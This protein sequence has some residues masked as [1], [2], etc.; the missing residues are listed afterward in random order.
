MHTSHEKLV[1]NVTAV[2][3]LNSPF[4]SV[5]TKLAGTMKIPVPYLALHCMHNIIVSQKH[6]LAEDGKLNK[7]CGIF[8]CA[9][10][11]TALLGLCSR[12][13]NMLLTGFHATIACLVL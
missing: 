6:P 10:T 9:Y 7:L 11:F 8:S 1:S 13:A 4:R 3:Y 5:T 12:K 2:H